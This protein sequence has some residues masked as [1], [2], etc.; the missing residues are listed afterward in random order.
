[1]SS[2]LTG[3]FLR[4]LKPSKLLSI[5]FFMSF[6]L[7]SSDPHEQKSFHRVHFH[8]LQTKQYPKATRNSDGIISHS[9]LW[10]EGTS[11]YLQSNI[12]N[13]EPYNAAHFLMI[14]LHFAFASRHRTYIEDFDVFFDE[15]RSAYTNK[16]R[17]LYLTEKDFLP[18]L[19]FLYLASEYLALSKQHGRPVDKKILDIV[20]NSLYFAWQKPSWQ[21]N[22]E[23]FANMRDRLKWKL[24]SQD[25]SKSYYRA[26]IDE[27]LFVFAIAANVRFLSEQERP[28]FIE[29]ILDL[30]YRVMKSEVT[31][32]RLTKNSW[33]F[34]PGVFT[35]HPDYAFAGWPDNRRDLPYEKKVSD[36]S[37]DSSHSFRWPLWLA[38]FQRA[39]NSQ[40]NENRAAYIL[41]LREGLSEQFFK[42]V[43]I[44]P[45]GKF[46]NYRATNFMDGRNGVYRYKF[47]QKKNP[48]WIGYGPYGLSG[49]LFIGWW[50][51][52]PN[53]RIKQV[54]CYIASRNTW[55]V[56]EKKLYQITK[57]RDKL[58]QLIPRLACKLPVL[59]SIVKP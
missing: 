16:S 31:F 10:D 2:T 43:L 40:N 53:T 3:V 50:S 6:I 34:Q 7:I 30:T 14:P 55:S 13:L 23:D 47:H 49:S 42:K 17:N 33:V 37:W 41:R 39:F 44:P 27:E 21:W 1:M 48:N 29:E 12:W 36:I 9:T 15:F 54:Y 19:Q 35:D 8:A 51:F 24:Q 4:L 59:P 25:V 38:S 18:R 11:I 28:E 52:L 22:R 26:I 56:Q 58:Y 45:S 5:C 20:V 57:T 46:Q 32:N